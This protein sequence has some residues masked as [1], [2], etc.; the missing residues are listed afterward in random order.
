[1]KSK[2]NNNKKKNKNNKKKG[3]GEGKGNE[4]VQVSTIEADKPK[5][6]FESPYRF[7]RTIEFNAEGVVIGIPQDYQSCP[8]GFSENEIE[9]ILTLEE[10]DEFLDAAL[11]YPAVDVGLL[12]LQSFLWRFPKI[13]R[14]RTK[15]VPY[16][17]CCAV[18][19]LKIYKETPKLEWWLSA[20]RSFR[21]AFWLD[22]AGDIMQASG[23]H[24]VEKHQFGLYRDEMNRLHWRF[25]KH[26]GSKRDVVAYLDKKI[27]CDCLVDLKQK[28]FEEPE[29][30]ECGHCFKEVTDTKWC[31]KCEAMEYFSK[32]CQITGWPKHREFCKLFRGRLTLEEFSSRCKRADAGKEA[33]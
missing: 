5:K 20:K 22:K 17:Y 24:T 19:F 21:T 16:L 1:M 33:S 3:T 28:V 11:E 13:L 26:C 29:F 27:P 14:N 25:V 7:N 9:G 2:R 12:M 10:I 4:A 30:R 15:V 18:D 23:P 8:H 31:V 6:K 32:E